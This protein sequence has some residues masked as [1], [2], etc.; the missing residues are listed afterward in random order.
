MTTASSVDILY[1]EGPCLV[2]CKPS[3]LLTQAPEGIDSM[4]LRLKNFLKQRDNK[5]GNIYLGVPHRLDRPASGAIVFARHVRACRRISD[6]FE[7]RSIRK[8]YW[9]YVAGLVEPL[10]GVWQD[11]MRK[12]PGEAR[13]ELVE[14]SHPDSRTAELRYRTIGTTRHGS[15][16]EIQLETGRTHQIR[17][18]ASSR[19]HPVLGDEQYGAK[20]PFGPQPEDHRQRAIALHAVSLT[21][22]HPMTRS[23]VHV[24]APVPRSWH[25]LVLER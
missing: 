21:F 5:T 3:G 19:G 9:A 23:K 2:L 8:L 20:I 7:A 1:E 13:A 10:E 25:E 22:Q 24:E 17:L 15:W 4:E 6:Q 11:T 18:Q 12:V 14:A 16:L